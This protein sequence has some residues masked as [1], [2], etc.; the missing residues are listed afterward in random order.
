MSASE[1]PDWL[2]TLRRYK[3]SVTLRGIFGRGRKARLGCWSWLLL[4]IRPNGL[5]LTEQG[6]WLLNRVLVTANRVR[7]AAFRL[8]LSAPPSHTYTGIT[9]NA[10]LAAEALMGKTELRTLTL[11]G[12]L[13]QQHVLPASEGNPLAA[14]RLWVVILSSLSC[15]HL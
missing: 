15:L 6:R 4:P 7:C 8:S 14:R 12:R 9:I 2:I 11:A 13:M 1:P 5:I 3:T 10:E